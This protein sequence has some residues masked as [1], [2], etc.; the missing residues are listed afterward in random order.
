MIRVNTSAENSVSTV[1]IV[2][3]AL[4]VEEAAQLQS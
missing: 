1:S 4:G 2:S 3:T